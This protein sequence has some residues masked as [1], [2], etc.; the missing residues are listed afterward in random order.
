[1]VSAWYTVNQIPPSLKK[2]S[3]TK[4]MPTCRM[5]CR[6]QVSKNNNSIQRSIKENVKEEPTAQV[7]VKAI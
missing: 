2:T 5:L 3:I 7:G 6:Q 1:M 4:T